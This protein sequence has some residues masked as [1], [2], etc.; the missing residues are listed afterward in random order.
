MEEQ[1]VNSL[2]GVPSPFALV[3]DAAG[4]MLPHSLVDLHLSGEVSWVELGVLL[5]AWAACCRM[6]LGSLMI[7][8]SLGVLAG[9][10]SPACEAHPHD[11]QAGLSLQ[12]VRAC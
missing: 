9:S 4:D 8:L 7:A 6:R 5:M 1:S 12:S 2:W 11:Q 10:V 3:M